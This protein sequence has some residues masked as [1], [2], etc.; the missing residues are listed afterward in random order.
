MTNDSV[1][2][3]GTIRPRYTAV[4]LMK[5]SREERRRILEEAADLAAADYATDRALTAFEAFGTDDL[6]DETG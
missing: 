4:E 1:R 3:G 6:Y 2:T 5:L